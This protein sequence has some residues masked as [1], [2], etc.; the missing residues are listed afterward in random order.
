MRCMGIDGFVMGN[1]CY[2]LQGQVID[3]S[4][5]RKGA[6]VELGEYTLKKLEW[7]YVEGAEP[8]FR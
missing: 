8:D 1:G 2:E 3:T 6:H 7:K 5:I 4:E